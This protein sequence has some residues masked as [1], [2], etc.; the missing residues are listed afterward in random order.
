MVL[1]DNNSSP[2]NPPSPPP[3]PNSLHH[4]NTHYKSIRIK[5]C[6]NLDFSC[7]AFH[8]LYVS[9]LSDHPPKRFKSTAKNP[10]WLAAMHEEMDALKHNNTCTLV[11]CPTISNVVGLIWVYHIKYTSD[12][13]FEWFKSRLVAQGFTQIP[14][15]D[16]SHTFSLV[17]KAST[18]RSVLSLS[19]LHKWC[20]YQ[21]DVKTP[22][23]VAI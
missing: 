19:V 2:G 14:N 12:G 23:Y 20:I 21:L 6:Y 15:L 13:S 18:I 11:P 9:L 17:V 10:K 16:Y 8:G 5:K 4:M 1:Q 22:S 7:I 3:E